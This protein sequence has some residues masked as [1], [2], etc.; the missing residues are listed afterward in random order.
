MND[1]V[2]GRASE[3]HSKNTRLAACVSR[4]DRENTSLAPWPPCTVL[5][6]GR[7][8]ALEADFFK[9]VGVYRGACRWSWRG[10]EV[11]GGR[12]GGWAGRG[13]SLSVGLEDSSTSLES[14][15]LSPRHTWDHSDPWTMTSSRGFPRFPGRCS[16]S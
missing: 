16:D 13:R 4:L 1:W 10:V 3:T 9:E 5:D 7:F 2:L 14:L 6:W 12:G 8:E 15:G 11:G